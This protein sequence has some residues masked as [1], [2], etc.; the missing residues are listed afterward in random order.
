[1]IEELKHKKK[2]Y[3]KKGFYAIDGYEKVWIDG[4]TFDS[5]FLIKK[6][7]KLKSNSTRKQNL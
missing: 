7:V 4:D 2:I 5:K 6:V 1:M 3:D